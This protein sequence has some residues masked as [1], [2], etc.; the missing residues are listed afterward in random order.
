M[1]RPP[2]YGNITNDDDGESDAEAPQAFDYLT[3]DTEE[4]DLLNGDADNDNVETPRWFNYY[5]D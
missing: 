2:E 1:Y 3:D 5:S 4:E